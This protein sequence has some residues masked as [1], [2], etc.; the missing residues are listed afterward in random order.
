MATYYVRVIGGSD[1]NSGLS[2]GAAWDTIAHAA[3]QVSA[4]DVVY[5]C[6]PYTALSDSYSA[7][8][9]SSTIVIST[10]GN[11]TSGPI[12]WLGIAYDSITEEFLS[13]DDDINHMAYI[14]DPGSGD[15]FHIS[16]SRNVFKNIK[17]LG[18]SAD[19]WYVTGEANIFH[20]CEVSNAAGFGFSFNTAEDCALTNC[21]VY[22]SANDG[23]NFANTCKRI[24]LYGCRTKDCSSTGFD[25][26]SSTVW[27]INCC[28]DS[29]NNAAR[30]FSGDHFINCTSYNDGTA[31]SFLGGTPGVL[32]NCLS[33]SA[34][35]SFAVNSTNDPTHLLLNNAYYDSDFYAE[36]NAIEIGT[37]QL[38]AD[39][40]IDAA[41]E[42]FTLNNHQEGGALCKGAGVPTYFTNI[43]TN[44]SVDIGC[45][46]P[47]TRRI[48][49]G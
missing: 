44:S 27:F 33:V 16:A 3:S 19:G 35:D 18:P 14:G 15:T 38:G 2:F 21:F 9:P 42:V 8:T 4:G 22:N 24:P 48:V 41:N 40:F 43:N 20:Q 34:S 46:Y 25:S 30:G 13:Y 6:C 26:N 47:P 11:D 37:I 1:G 49:S 28:S 12:S 17:V 45:F 7:F 5:L 29:N 31:F 32:I 10:S 23:F 39:P 36:D